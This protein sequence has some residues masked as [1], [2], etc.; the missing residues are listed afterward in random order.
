MMNFGVP[1][2]F[3]ISGFLLY[4]PFVAATFAGTALPRPA[5]SSAGR[6]HTRPTTRS[7]YCSC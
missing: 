7:R 2:F 6:S 1:L 5:S 4:R 3:V